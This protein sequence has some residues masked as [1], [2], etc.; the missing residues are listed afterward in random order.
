MIGV[1]LASSW[2]KQI[3][4]GASASQQS[5]LEEWTL[6]NLDSGLRSSSMSRLSLVLEIVTARVWPMCSFW[7]S[8]SMK[9]GNL[10]FDRAA[11]L[12]AT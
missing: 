8:S 12:A 7:H 10:A 3:K 6:A 1:L 11:V 2:M 5:S 9:H 4:L